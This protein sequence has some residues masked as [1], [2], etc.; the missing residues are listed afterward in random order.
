M[1][2]LFVLLSTGDLHIRVYEYEDVGG[3]NVSQMENIKYLWVE[4]FML[5]KACCFH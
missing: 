4:R 3:L 2:I 5:Y 1:I